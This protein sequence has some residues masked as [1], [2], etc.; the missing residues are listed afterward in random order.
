MSRACTHCILP[1]CPSSNQEGAGGWGGDRGGQG[2][3]RAPRPNGLW[4]QQSRQPVAGRVRVHGHCRTQGF[5]L[6]PACRPA[7]LPATQTC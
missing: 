2:W 7:Q 3:G 5:P 6:E 4:L 1:S